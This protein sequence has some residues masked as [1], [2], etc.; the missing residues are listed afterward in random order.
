MK[1]LLAYLGAVACVV[2]VSGVVLALNFKGSRDALAI[3]VS[4]VIV[5][6]VEMCSF[7][8]DS[9]VSDQDAAYL[10]VWGGLADGVAG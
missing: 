2:L 10:G 1:G 6:V 8:E 9:F 5:L 4:G 3:Q 7:G